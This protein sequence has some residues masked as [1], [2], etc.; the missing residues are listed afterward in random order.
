MSD[1]TNSLLRKLQ[2]NKSFINYKTKKME[3]FFTF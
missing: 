3:I 2:N 1:K